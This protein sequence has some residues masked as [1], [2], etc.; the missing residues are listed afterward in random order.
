MRTFGGLLLVAGLAGFFY[1]SSHLSGLASIPEGTSLSSYLDATGEPGRNQDYLLAYGRAG[2][3]CQRC[4]RPIERRLIGQRG[5][6][7]CPH[8]QRV[9]SPSPRGRVSG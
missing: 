5:T 9:R 7:Y 6:W 2:Q 3:P 1:C 4:R 8:C